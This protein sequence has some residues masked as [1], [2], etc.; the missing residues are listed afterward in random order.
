VVFICDV[1]HHVPDR[2]NWLTKLHAE[3]AKGA[4]LVLIEFKSGDLPQGP[5]EKKIPKAEIVRLSKEAGFSLK[6]EQPDLLPYQEFLVFER[7]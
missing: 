6:E 4:R 2:A 7:P 1:L 5:P 3:M